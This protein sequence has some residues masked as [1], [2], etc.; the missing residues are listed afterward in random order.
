MIGQDYVLKNNRFKKEGC[1]FPTVPAILV[2]AFFFPYRIRT[3]KIFHRSSF[4]N[5]VG[6]K[7]NSCLMI[8]CN[9][10]IIICSLPERN[11]FISHRP[12]SCFKPISEVQDAIDEIMVITTSSMLSNCH[13]ALSFYISLCYLSI[14]LSSR[15][16]LLVFARLSFPESSYS[17]PGWRFSHP[18]WKWQVC[19]HVNSHEYACGNRCRKS[20]K[21]P[22]CK[23]FEIKL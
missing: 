18:P 1:S 21:I 9:I 15:G 8:V 20:G 22:I 13:S 12:P 5:L 17:S 23:Y 14:L 4:M 19:E 2:G 11:M 7:W 16:Q 6:T 3:Q 10:G